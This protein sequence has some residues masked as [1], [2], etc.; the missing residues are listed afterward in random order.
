MSTN[1]R[2]SCQPA[3]PPIPE[4]DM[5]PQVAMVRFCLVPE[6]SPHDGHDIWSDCRNRKVACPG[7]RMCFKLSTQ[8]VPGRVDALHR[9]LKHDDQFV[10]PHSSNIEVASAILQAK[11][12][13]IRSFRK[14]DLKPG[15]NLSSHGI[16]SLSKQG[17]PSSKDWIVLPHKV[18]P[19][20]Q[21]LPRIQS[22]SLWVRVLYIGVVDIGDEFDLF[23]HMTAVA[24]KKVRE[25]TFFAVES[26]CHRLDSLPSDHKQVLPNR[27]SRR[28]EIP[29]HPVVILHCQLWPDLASEQVEELCKYSPGLGTVDAVSPFG[30]RLPRDDKQ[31]WSDG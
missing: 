17:C 13:P 6:P 12:M 9:R 25:Q 27:C 15:S 23:T 30:A 7:P 26:V 2:R 29:R 31:G 11:I 1:V 21:N 4:L 19:H 22:N 20:H 16:E 24:V 5:Q 3:L 28:K 18:P 14:W 10:S 8:L